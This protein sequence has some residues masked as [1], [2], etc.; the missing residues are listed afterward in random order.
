MRAVAN[1]KDTVNSTT[2][3]R[4][5]QEGGFTDAVGV[6]D[7]KKHLID[8]SDEALAQA[9]SRYATDPKLRLREVE[10]QGKIRTI[11]SPT[12]RSA[13]YPRSTF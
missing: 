4:K 12:S 9:L 5:L 7:A 11:P 8:H 10:T 6:F 1:S 2:F 3:M 13:R